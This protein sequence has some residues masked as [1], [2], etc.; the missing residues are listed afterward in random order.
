MCTIA[1]ELDA[2]LTRTRDLNPFPKLS[3]N[4]ASVILRE[5]ESKRYIVSQRQH[6]SSVTHVLL[7]L[8]IIKDLPEQIVM[9][10]TRNWYGMALGEV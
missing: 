2:G 7:K 4:N 10:G 6:G 9:A 1:K 3:T 8:T 5:L